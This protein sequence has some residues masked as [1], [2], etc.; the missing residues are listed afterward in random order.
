ME[1]GKGKQNVFTKHHVKCREK[2]PRMDRGMDMGYITQ[3]PILP[4]LLL[5]HL[6]HAWIMKGGHSLGESWVNHF[7][8]GVSDLLYS[9]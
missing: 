2:T 4:I 6:L 9:Q 5:T 8:Q 3:I 7:G 1:P